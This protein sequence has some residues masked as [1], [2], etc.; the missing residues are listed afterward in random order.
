MPAGVAKS[1]VSCLLCDFKGRS[2][3][4]KRHVKL[5]HSKQPCPEGWEAAPGKPTVWM[6]LYVAN[7][8]TKAK[9]GVCL[10][11][12]SCIKNLVKDGAR[13]YVPTGFK[14]FAS[15]TCKIKQVRQMSDPTVKVVKAPKE[16]VASGDSYKLLFEKFK[17][18]LRKYPIADNRK[19]KLQSILL[20][21]FDTYTDDDVTNYEKVLLQCMWEF[22]T[23]ENVEE[24]V[25]S[26]TE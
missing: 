8:N 3:A 17:A 13:G 18:D 24:S 19:R 6:H 9:D 10:E 16:T 26:D 22:A 21:N 25:E 5:I 14:L 7:G 1:D 2:D 23:L 15:H 20:D 12:G 11:C 4:V